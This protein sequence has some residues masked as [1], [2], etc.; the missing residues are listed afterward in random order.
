MGHILHGRMAQ[1]VEHIV[2]IDGVTGSSP[3]ATTKIEYP[4][5]RLRGR[6]AQ[7][8]E[9][10]VHIDGVTGSSPVATTKKEEPSAEGGSSFLVF[11]PQDVPV[12]RRCETSMGRGA[13]RPQCG[14]QRGGSVVSKGACRAAA[15]AGDY[16]EP[17][18][19]QRDRVRVRPPASKE[20]TVL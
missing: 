12:S 18:R 10:I 20:R 3:V 7:L 14:M 1:L 16:C 6:M 4:V 9:H 11:R 17:D 19:A 15:K 13:E 2:H 8:V 5:K